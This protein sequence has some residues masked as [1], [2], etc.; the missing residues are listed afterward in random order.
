MAEELNKDNNVVYFPNTENDR[1]G[2]EEVNWDD[3]KSM[4]VTLELEDGAEMDCEVITV[5]DFEGS[6]YIAV[7]PTK[8]LEEADEDTELSAMLYGL[9]GATWEEMKLSNIDDDIYEKVAARFEEVMSEDDEEE[10]E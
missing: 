6:N 2:K 9:G 1:S 8:E 10:E 4:T 5:F 7:V 3:V